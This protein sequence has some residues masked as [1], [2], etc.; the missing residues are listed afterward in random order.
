MKKQ[1]YFDY[2][3]TTPVD[4]RVV[5]AMLPYFLKYYGNTMSGHSPGQKAA[6]TLENIRQLFA[7]YINASSEEIIF[8]GSATES[9]NLALKGIMFANRLKKNHLIVSQI[10]HDCI[11]ESSQ[12][13]E[14]QGFKITYLPVDKNGFINIDQLE[15]TITPQTALVSII[16]GNN[17][18]GTVQDIEAIGK[19]CR[20]KGV[21]FHTDAVQSFGKLTI[22][23]KKQN[24]D[25]LTA[26]SHKIYGP[27]GAALLF[28]RNGVR[29]E[30]ILHG[31]GHERGLRSSTVN[32]PAIVGF[33]KALEIIK[34]EGKKENE[35]LSKLKNYLI[36]KVLTN[37]K[38]T[39]LNGDSQKRLVNNINISFASVEGESLMMELD[40]QNIAVS[41]GSACSSKILMPS[42]VLMA[43]GRQPQEAHGSLRISL[44]RWTKKSDIDF[45]VINLK[46]IIK[47][48]RAIS[49][50]N[51]D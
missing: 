31:G 47:K 46:K 36:K 38:G 32:L 2:A 17:E 26:S 40:F 29:I 8:T 44:G 43:M 28:V 37:I 24:I 14:K 23:V 10:E 39:Q 18:V 35:R 27:K 13:L 41:T 20:S 50:F 6:Q 22:D 42:H 51:Y 4:P 11:L 33:G 5:N 12:W 1:I 49:P 3:A 25:L 19:L 45:L 16:H 48:L 21:Y 9:N 30:P 7:D 34:K 15:K